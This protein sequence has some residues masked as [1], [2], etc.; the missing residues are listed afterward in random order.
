MRRLRCLVEQQNTAAMQPPPSLLPDDTQE[1]P[2]VSRTESRAA[3]YAGV[4]SKPSPDLATL[5]RYAKETIPDEQRALYWQLLLGVTPLAPADRETASDARSEQYAELIGSVCAD[6]A[7]ATPSE[8]RHRIDLDVP[9][10]MPNMHFFGAQGA[11]EDGPEGVASFTESQLALRRVL[12]LYARLNA[13]IGYVQGMNEIVGHLLYTFCGGVSANA[14]PAIEANVFF[15]FQRLTQSLG[16]SFC[17]ELDNDPTVGVMGSLEQYNRVLRICDPELHA[18]V[19]GINLQPAFYAFRWVTLMFT[20]EFSV[21]DVLSMWDFLLSFDAA[22][23]TTVVH[24]VAVAMMR[25]VRTELLEMTFSDAIQMLLAY[26]PSVE[27]K[28]VRSAALLLIDEH[29]FA[30][31]TP[32]AATPTSTPLVNLMSK[33]KK[34]FSDF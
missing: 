30:P 20:Q 10:T 3:M 11:D 14:T 17:R 31:T 24:F 9:R 8:D 1:W 4:A 6:L 12:H 32:R 33:M 25:Q 5:R 2:E 22:E 21:P 15:C 7:D 16:D 28:E 29:G 19:M 13:G 34:K 26:P 23:L 18:H 27:V